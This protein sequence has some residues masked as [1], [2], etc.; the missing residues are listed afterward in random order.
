MS[1]GFVN[2]N[3]ENIFTK[4][5]NFLKDEFQKEMVD[6]ALLLQGLFIL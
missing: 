1:S 3:L 2:A 5:D 4:V 6:R